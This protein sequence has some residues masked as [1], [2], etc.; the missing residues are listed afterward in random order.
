VKD[1][2]TKFK[3]WQRR[4]DAADQHEYQEAK[5]MTK[6]MVAEAKAKEYNELYQKLNSRE[7]EKMVYRLAK[8]RERATRD[9]AQVKTV[10]D[11]EGKLLVVEEQVRHR[12]GEYF[13]QLLNE[14]NP[15]EALAEAEKNHGPIQQIEEKEV[16]EALKNMKSGKA[17]GPDNIPIEA[18]RAC[19]KGGIAVLTKLFNEI[20][21]EEKMP[22]AW[23]EKVVVPIFK[24]KGDIQD[25]SNYRGIKLMS[26]TMKLWE[27]ILERRLR[28]MVEISSNQ[29]GFMAGRSTTDAIFALRVLL[30]KYRE[31][32][33]DLHMVFIDLEKAYD[34]VP[35]EVVWWCMKRRGIPEQ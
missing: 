9:V 5:K 1:K 33:R 32:Q 3:K 28:Q 21:R 2:K 6:R 26:H 25:C 15:R 12:W 8:A 14:E 35:R 22:E 7:G 20:L 16:A 19:E 30:E 17:T 34:R 31:K 4:K 13:G 18:L 23:R 27:R 24:G 29:F 10:K 11:I